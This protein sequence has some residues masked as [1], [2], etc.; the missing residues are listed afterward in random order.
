MVIEKIVI[1]SPTPGSGSSGRSLKLHTEIRYETI[2]HREVYLASRLTDSSRNRKGY[3]ETI[4][5]D[6]A[7]W[8][9]RVGR[10]QTLSGSSGIRAHIFAGEFEL[11]SNVLLSF[12]FYR[13]SIERFRPFFNL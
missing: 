7:P 12:L 4:P 6:Y 2:Q 10:I 8:R 9:V 13:L 1:N 5:L 11:S 3:R